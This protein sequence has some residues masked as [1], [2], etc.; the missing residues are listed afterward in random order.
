MAIARPQSGQELASSLAD[1]AAQGRTIQLGGAFSKN[2]MAGPV[3]PADVVVST[4]ALNQ[5]LQYE[6]NDLTMSV[7]SGLPWAELTATLAGNRQMIPLDPPFSAHATVGGVIASNSS[8][9]RRRVYGTARDMVIG[10]QFAT[11]EGKLIN[12]GG[13]VVKNVAGLDMGKLLIGS[14]GTLAALV[15]VNFKLS[16]IP[17]ACE[18]FVRSFQSASE[19]FTLRDQVLAGALQPSA[20]DILNPPASA[21]VG[22]EKWSLVV[23]AS[24]NAAAVARYSSELGGADRAPKNLL[25][26][27]QEFVPAFLVDHPDGAV[28]RASSTLTAMKELMAGWQVPAFARAGSGV[29]Y[30]CFADAREAAVPGG[31]GAVEFAPEEKKRELALWPAPGDDLAMMKRIKDMF[32]PKHLLNR[33]R[34][35]GRI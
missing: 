2:R 13:M 27:I 25:H 14:F 15:S 35:Y 20:L 34:L 24:G 18:T 30:A 31:R 21:R 11:L 29:C 22:L 16:P 3:E 7:G 4:S 33:G 19:A 10:M 6:P 9:P 5:V 28:V 12:S 26:R 32:D 17:E 1:C 8:G 23:E